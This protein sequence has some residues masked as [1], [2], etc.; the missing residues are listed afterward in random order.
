MEM[1]KKWRDA[2][3][4]PIALVTPETGSADITGPQDCSA[5]NC[6]AYQGKPDLACRPSPSGSTVPFF[7]PVDKVY[8]QD[9]D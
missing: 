5:V 3:I 6:T 1:R 7:Q 4:E 2:G 9:V 8:Q